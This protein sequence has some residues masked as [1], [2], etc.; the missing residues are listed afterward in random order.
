MYIDA[1][2][3]PNTGYQTVDI[4]SRERKENQ[5]KLFFLVFL[6][7]IILFAVINKA[8]R[9]FLLVN[10]LDKLIIERLILR[11]IRDLARLNSVALLNQSC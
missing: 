3:Q 11:V 10:H 4:I 6:I 2:I 7:F 9:G 8:I 1:F 5:G